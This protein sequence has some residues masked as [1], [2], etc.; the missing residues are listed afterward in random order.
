VDPH[1]EVVFKLECLVDDEFGVFLASL[2][3][4]TLRHNPYASR[5]NAD[6]AA[7][8]ANF[9]EVFERGTN[10]LEV[11]TTGVELL[12]DL[13]PKPDSKR[14]TR[15]LELRRN[16]EE[17]AEVIVEVGRLEN[18]GRFELDQ[19]SFREEKVDETLDLGG[20]EER[21]TTCENN[22]VT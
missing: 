11:R 19:A 7:K 10:E 21:F 9:V 20:L 15:I 17:D 8:L 1:R 5:T 12:K 2:M 16:R 3:R 13:R 18:P 14:V 22:Q 6:R 4:Y